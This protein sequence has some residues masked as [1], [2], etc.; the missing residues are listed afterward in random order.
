MLAFDEVE[1]ELAGETVHCRPTLRAA[2]RLEKRYGGFSN[3]IA[4]INEGNLTVIADVIAHTSD[5]ISDIPQFLQILEGRPIG[6]EIKRVIGPLTQLV[7]KMA[8]LDE[9]PAKGTKES[10]ASE[11]IT[12]AKYF[13]TLFAN[14]CGVLGWT[15]ETAWSATPAEINSA[16]RA[17]IELLQAL[18]GSSK[19]DEGRQ[20]DHSEADVAE[21]LVQ[22]RTLALTG[23]NVGA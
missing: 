7:M 16:Y 12:F 13:E 23:Q 15:P 3:L 2:A 21:G 1:I 22:L 8:G 18:F 10:G 14:A 19:Q 9:A 6:P 20:L 17:R 5:T 11:R 4:S